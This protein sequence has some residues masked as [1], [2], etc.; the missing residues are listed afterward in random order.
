M[1]NYAYICKGN[2]VL[3]QF[4]GS[5]GTAAEGAE[6]EDGDGAGEENAGGDL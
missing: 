4:F 6:E 2:G 3:Y 5:L 1:Y